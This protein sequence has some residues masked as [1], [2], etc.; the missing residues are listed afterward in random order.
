MVNF[1]TLIY[2]LERIGLT[3]VLL[4]FLLIFTIVW[5]VLKKASILASDP[6]LNDRLSIVVATALSLIA[7]VPH[8]VGGYP[9]GID[10]VEIINNALPSVAVLLVGIV[11]VLILIGIWGIKADAGGKNIGAIIAMLAFLVVGYIF[12]ESA[13]WSIR[14]NLFGWIDY[15]TKAVLVA[16]LVFALIIWFVTGG[17]ST[18]PS[19]SFGEHFSDFLGFLSRDAGA[20]KS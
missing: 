14:Y 1:K 11:M 3:D 4:P 17:D 10:V 16:I 9:G 18:E 12:A 15:E 13:G 8:V 2:T 5:A 7:V 6:K 20:K 19:K